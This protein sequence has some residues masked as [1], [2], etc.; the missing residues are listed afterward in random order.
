MT[1]IADPAQRFESHFH[2][3]LHFS[4]PKESLT[5]YTVAYDN[6]PRI[7]TTSVYTYQKFSLL[8][9]AEIFNSSFQQLL[10]CLANNAVKFG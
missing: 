5:Q 1:T 2:L 4:D 3:R 10:L 6:F 7:H 9:V 8:N